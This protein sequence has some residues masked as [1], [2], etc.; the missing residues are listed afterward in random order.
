MLNEQADL[1][2]T[3]RISNPDPFKP[4]G[5]PPGKSTPSFSGD[6]MKWYHPAMIRQD[7]SVRDAFSASDARATRA[8]SFN[9][10]ARIFTWTQENQQAYPEN[11]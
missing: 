8:T 2:E 7:F 4:K 9:H 10:S 1:V 3:T 6:L 11:S 5:R